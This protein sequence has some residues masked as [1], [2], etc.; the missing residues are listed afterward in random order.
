[1]RKCKLSMKQAKFFGL[2]SRIVGECT[3]L[4]PSRMNV[5]NGDLDV[6]GI[7]FV[8]RKRLMISKLGARQVQ[9]VGILGVADA[10]ERMEV[11]RGRIVGGETGRPGK[12]CVARALDHGCEEFLEFEVFT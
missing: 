3:L 11:T 8:S 2:Y 4:V 7:V 9:N 1:M 5:A 10:P 6:F 12:A